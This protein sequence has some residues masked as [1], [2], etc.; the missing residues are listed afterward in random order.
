MVTA[1]RILVAERDPELLELV[2]PVLRLA[3]HRVTA[4]RDGLQALG[5]WRNQPFDLVVL[6]EVLPRLTGLEVLHEMRADTERTQSAVVMLSS[7]ASR[8]ELRTAVLAGAD[9]VLRI[10]FTVQGLRICVEELLVERALVGA[11]A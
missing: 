4:A 11:S 2:V 1:G 9:E 6:D 3:G 10:P 8:E 5:L 7:L